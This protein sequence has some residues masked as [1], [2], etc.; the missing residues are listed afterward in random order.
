MAIYL[1]LTAIRRELVLKMRY[2]ALSVM[3]LVGATLPH[4]QGL[5]LQALEEDESFR[6]SKAGIRHEHADKGCRCRKNG[7][8]CTGAASACQGTA[9]TPRRL[10][11]TCCDDSDQ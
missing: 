4:S 2:A 9:Q 8:D 5:A 11:H 6:S 1:D 3:P 10:A 7:L